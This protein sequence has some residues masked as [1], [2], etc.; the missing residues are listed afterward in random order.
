ME[1]DICKKNF[2]KLQFKKLEMFFREFC[3]DPKAEGDY[4]LRANKES[5]E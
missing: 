4:E 3:V 1:L 2:P 5:F